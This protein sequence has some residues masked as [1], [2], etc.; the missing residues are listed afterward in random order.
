MIRSVGA[1]ACVLLVIAGLLGTAPAAAAP[2]NVTMSA[3]IDDLDIAKATAGE[4]IRLDPDGAIRVGIG[5]T[6]NTDA[7]VDIRRVELAGE[8][9][10]LTFFAY[11]TT[12]QLTLAPGK[13]ESLSYQLELDGLAGQAT[14]L[15]GAD[16]S[17]IG[18][19]NK[20][21]AA[22][23]TVTDV[24]GSLISVYGLFGIALAVL[25]AL[26]LIDTALA[27]ARHR[28][29]PNRWQRGVR[30]LAPGVGIGLVFG[31]TASVARWWVPDTGLWLAVAGVSATVAFLL[32]Y[33][34]PTPEVNAGEDE[35]AEYLRAEQEYADQAQPE[36]ADPDRPYPGYGVPDQSDPGYGDPDRSVPGYGVPDR[37]YPGYG[38]PDRSVPGYGDPDRSD[39]GYGDAVRPDAG[40][41]DAGAD[42]VR[43]LPEGPAQ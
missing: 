42:T 16:L 19:D 17:V 2:D 37:P 14:G 38:D 25:T 3:T 29:S 5:L 15:I 43:F 28:L 18:T 39:P 8:V 40:Y 35:L 10:G 23:G 21:V 36:Y 11:S 32:G 12:V 30:V 34:S 22:V 26:A 27:I 31:F 7:P 13:S 9:L 41:G 20:V 6:N 1:R 4:P 33:C 24:R